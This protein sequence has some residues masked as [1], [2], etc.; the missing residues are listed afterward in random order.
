MLQ[1]IQRIEIC[2]KQKSPEISGLFIYYDF[3]KYQLAMP[4]LAFTLGPASTAVEVF[5]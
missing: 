1:I 4:N 2:K 3:I 5:T